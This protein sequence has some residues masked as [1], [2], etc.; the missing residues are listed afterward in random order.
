MKNLFQ[1]VIVLALVIALAPAAS[2][3]GKFAVSA[4][5]EILL[6]TGNFH[7]SFTLGYGATARGQYNF[8]SQLSAGLDAGYFAFSAKSVAAG[9]TD[10]VFYAIP[11]RVFGKYYFMPEESSIRFYGMVQAGFWFWTNTV[12]TLATVGPVGATLG[13]F[14]STSKSNFNYVPMLGVELPADNKVKLDVSLRYEGVATTGS[15]TSLFGGRLG[16]N[17]SL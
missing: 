10:P 12:K 15:K 2:A 17:F 8:S 13:S 3:Q 5:P 9:L 11:V 4:G 14:V 7:N 1:V 16:V 6:P